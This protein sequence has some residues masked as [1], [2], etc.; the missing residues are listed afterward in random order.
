MINIIGGLLGGHSSNKAY[1]VFSKCYETKEQDF[2]TD[3][4]VAGT[5]HRPDCM[6]VDL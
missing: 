2:S 4:T 3:G 1:V 5:L 6:Y